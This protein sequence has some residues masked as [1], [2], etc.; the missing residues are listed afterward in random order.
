M[1]RP[2]NIFFLQKSVSPVRPNPAE[3]E[4]NVRPLWRFFAF[5]PGM[6]LT[7]GHSCS[8]LFTLELTSDGPREQASRYATE[9]V[10]S[11]E[12]T[13]GAT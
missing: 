13:A 10:L 12:G 4:R 11:G 9:F 3:R 1:A 5:E 6:I 2:A 8:K 7:F